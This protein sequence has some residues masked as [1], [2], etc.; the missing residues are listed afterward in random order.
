M[1]QLELKESTITK[2]CVWTESCGGGVRGRG[3]GGYL[4][5]GLQHDHLSGRLNPGFTVHLHGDVGLQVD[6]DVAALSSIH[7]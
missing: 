4:E 3:V 5:G 2:A 1:F 7:T 6:L